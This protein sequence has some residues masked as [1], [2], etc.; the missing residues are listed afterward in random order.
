MNSEDKKTDPMENEKLNLFTHSTHNLFTGKTPQSFSFGLPGYDMKSNLIPSAST[1]APMKTKIEFI[2]DFMQD[3]PSAIISPQIT[4]LAS[5]GAHV[6]SFNT[7]EQTIPRYNSIDKPNM[8]QLINYEA[9]LKDN[10]QEGNKG[11]W[12]WQYGQNTELNHNPEKNTISRSSGADD[13]IMINFNDMTPD[14][15]QNMIRT[16]LVSD[17]KISG[18]DIKNK[19]YEAKNKNPNIDQ[20]YNFVPVSNEQDQKFSTETVLTS[21][22]YNNWQKKSDNINNKSNWKIN[23]FSAV[24]SFDPEVSTAAFQSKIN[25]QYVYVPPTQAVIQSNDYEKTFYEPKRIKSLKTDTTSISE[26]NQLIANNNYKDNY[27]IWT[28]PVNAEN[29]TIATTQ[30]SYFSTRESTPFR[31]THNELPQN[32]NGFIPILN[33]QADYSHDKVINQISTESVADI[34]KGNVFLKNVFSEPSNENPNNIPLKNTYKIEYG[35]KSDINT[36]EGNA[37]N[38]KPHLQLPSYHEMKSVTIKPIDIADM[39]NYISS[40]NQFESSKIRPKKESFNNFDEELQPTPQQYRYEGSEDIFDH[41]I[42]TYRNNERQDR[43]IK[44]YK[45]LQ[46]NNGD[47]NKD[48]DTDKVNRIL[49]VSQG[50]NLPPLGRA[51]PSMKSYLPPTYY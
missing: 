33:A 6:P 9:P 32:K 29:K 38:F 7:A 2:Q 13:D 31:S 3:K 14:H 42:N 24:G 17:Q 39:L 35:R 15:Y 20:S 48:K 25:S 4:F 26:I 34:L 1:E 43:I 46:R 5:Q 49:T 51:G 44:N 30:K 41:S 23:Q 8:L 21:T 27:D 11:L 10:D 50:H 19:F 37:P 16:Q 40:K 18:N 12:R 36:N 45:I 47:L 28:R 22:P